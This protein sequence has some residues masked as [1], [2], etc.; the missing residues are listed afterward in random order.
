MIK[1]FV[2]A[3][4]S[5][6]SG[7]VIKQ[8]LLERSRYPHVKVNPTTK[9]A[10]VQGTGSADD[11]M[12]DYNVKD[13]ALSGSTSIGSIKGGAGG[14]PNVYNQIANNPYEQSIGT[15]LPF[16]TPVTNLTQSFTQSLDTIAGIFET[17]DSKQE[18]FYNGEYSG[19]EYV[20]TNGELSPGCFVYLHGL[21]D[22]VNYS[23][24]IFN[25]TA[26]Y[27]TEARFIDAIIPQC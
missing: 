17:I 22:T 2:P 23:A 6:S 11:T 3:K 21:P 7:V 14:G 12:I 24:S 9:I 15:Q 19:S 26:S 27:V 20:V 8:H 10:R 4:S 1:D 5:L 13:L 18:E 16:G 25:P